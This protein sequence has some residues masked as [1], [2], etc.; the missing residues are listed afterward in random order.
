ME[1]INGLSI[2][3]F[4]KWIKIQANDVDITSFCTP[5]HSTISVYIFLEKLLSLSSSPF[6]FF[7]QP[8]LKSKIWR[9][10]MEILP[11]YD[12][13][14]IQTTFVVLSSI[15]LNLRRIRFANLFMH[16]PY[17][18]FENHT[19]RNWQCNTIRLPV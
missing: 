14:N 6:L 13:F 5:A 17:S 1:G 12:L 19:A 2:F 15:D 4:K 8:K 11:S 16:R 10:Q 18:L 9:I 3:L 7:F